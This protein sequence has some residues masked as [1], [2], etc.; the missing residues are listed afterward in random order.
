MRTRRPGG[1]SLIELLIVI[2]LMAIL[3]GVVLP[4]SD[5]TMHDQLRGTA[6]ILSTDLAY[7]RSLAVAND[8]EY[9]VTFNVKENRYV[10]EHAGDDATLDAL[11][12]SPF[13]AES[14]PVN[15]HIVDL[16][17]LPQMGAGVR[18]AA[19]GRQS[20]FVERAQEVTFGPLGETETSASTVI[21]LA[22]GQS[23]RTRYMTVTV[24]PVTGMAEI[25]EFTDEGPPKWLIEDAPIYAV[26]VAPVA[27][28]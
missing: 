3:A 4:S 25:G 9:K 6:Q 8:S 24:H 11:P 2:S 15:Q 5:P 7:A 17:D 13:R 22:A 27:P 26:P 12:D 18:L 16:D 21:W 10:L 20:T 1:F 23:S 28:W 19:V 14:D